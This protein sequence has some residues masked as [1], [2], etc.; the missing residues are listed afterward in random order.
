MR[1]NRTLLWV[2]YISAPFLNPYIAPVFSLD[3]GAGLTQIF[4][5]HAEVFRS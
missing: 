5:C 1:L 2:S 3:L 4:V